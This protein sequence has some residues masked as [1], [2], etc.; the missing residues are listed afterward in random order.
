MPQRI[1]AFFSRYTYRRQHRGPPLFRTPL[2]T[3]LKENSPLED[4]CHQ[5]PQSLTHGHPPPLLPLRVVMHALMLMRL[6]DLMGL[7]ELM[8]LDESRRST[9]LNS[10]SLSAIKVLH[11]SHILMI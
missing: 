8:R 5:A 10:K 4:K 7:D 2:Q 11:S 1:S 3:S 6:D 9:K